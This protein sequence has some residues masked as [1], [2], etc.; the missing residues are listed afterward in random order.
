MATHSRFLQPDI[1]YLI[2][3]R[4]ESALARC[5]ADSTTNQGTSMNKRFKALLA[6]TVAV[7][8]LAVTTG[9][10][11]QQAPKPEALIKARQSAFNLVAFNSSRIKASLDGQYNKDDVIKAANTI[12]AVANSGLGALFPAG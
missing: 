2:S 12:A 6:S 8:I 9:V 10:L 4:I 3:I 1:A 11:A 5:K 7:T